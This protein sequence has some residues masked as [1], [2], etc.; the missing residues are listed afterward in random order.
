[1][2]KQLIARGQ[3][4]ILVQKDSYTIHQSVGEYIFPANNNGALSQ[5]V[6]FSSTIKVTLGDDNLTNFTIGAVTKPAGFRHHREQHEQD[7]YLLGCRG[8][9]YYGG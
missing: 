9:N 3:A 2:E 8:H 1:M 4:T 6:T 5:A 7:G